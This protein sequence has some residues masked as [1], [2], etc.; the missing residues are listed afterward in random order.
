MFEMKNNINSIKKNAS[1]IFLIL[2]TVLSFTSC[3]NEFDSDKKPNNS[4]N[5]P[6]EISSVSE[7]RED[8]PV[9]QGVLEGSYIVRGKN[10]GTFTSI[11]INDY[12]VLVSP[13]LGTDGLIFIKIPENAPYVGQDNIL[14]IENPAGYA[15]YD[16]SLLTI[17]EFTEATVNGVKVVNIIGGDFT[18]TK[19][20]T[21]VSGSEE[22]GDLVERPAEI[23]SVS[24]TM[25]T[26]AVPSGV[27]Q[28][29]IYVETTR[30]AVAQSDSYGFSYS[31]YIDE[32]HSEWS[33]GGWGGSQ[34][35]ASTEQAL[36]QYSIKSVREGWAGLTFTV[37]N[38]RFDEYE[39]IT[40]SIYGTGAS[41]DTVTLAINDFD[42]GAEQQELV[43]VPGEWTKFVIPLNDFYPTGGAPDKI[44]RL[45]FQESSN[46][47][48]AQYIFYVDDFG[49]L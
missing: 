37:P 48:Q 7:T 2:M 40:V 20:V 11:T 36:G 12:P 41:G 21:F 8:K 31:I 34:D 6:P 25:V 30:G 4:N 29:Y 17:D 1:R 14:K 38:I 49:F 10:L 35:L 26:A 5:L 44:T 28:A 19:S 13:A 22:T 24:E 3:E 18:D 16:F 33:I 9:T 23:I 43:L 45:D 15:T 27:E 39:S 32:L 47:G 46:T 42:G